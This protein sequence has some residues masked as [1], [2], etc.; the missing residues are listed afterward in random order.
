MGG[1]LQ[2]EWL[3]IKKYRTFW[4]LL[5]LFAL[6]FPALTYMGYYFQTQI[7][8]QGRAILNL[9]QYFQFPDIWQATAYLGSFLLILPGL[10]VI[11]LTTNEFVF[12][13]Q[14]QNIIDGWS[15][16]QFITAKWML[17]FSLSL[18][19]MI[20]L[21][22][23]GLLFGLATTR[24]FS[25]TA[26]LEKIHFLPF[27]FVQ[28]LSY[29]SV[30]FLFG[31]AFKRAGLAIGLFFLYTWVIEKILMVIL[32]KYFNNLGKFLPLEVTNRLIPNPVYR[33]IPGLSPDT[34]SPYMYLLVA[35]IYIL[36]IITLTTR[37]IRRADL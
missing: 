22:L 34:T 21:L 3:K 19:A 2:I 31:M 27:F 11:T 18:V 12:K 5:I 32:D 7:P 25:G 26:L 29:L 8:R 10:L 1:L 30:A 33:I 4:V 23:T 20:C 35:G 14:R 36:V 9:L 24:P 17:I 13:T 15:R 37:M 28:A 6:A 16:G